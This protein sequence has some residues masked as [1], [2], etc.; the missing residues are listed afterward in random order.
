MNKGYIYILKS[1]KDAKS[2]VGS[3]NDLTRRIGEHN[4]GKC[5]S[6]KARIPMELVYM[7]EYDTLGEARKRER[8]LKTTSGRRVLK[9]IFQN[10]GP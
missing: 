7:E 9:K 2:Y 4:T 10:I 8:F 1:L 6:T 3:T 5:K